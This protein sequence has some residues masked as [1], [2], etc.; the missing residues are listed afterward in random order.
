MTVAV[1]QVIVAVLRACL[2]VVA[3]SSTTLLLGAVLVLNTDT[4]V[5]SCHQE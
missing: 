4:V 5:F 3:E 1:I 2:V